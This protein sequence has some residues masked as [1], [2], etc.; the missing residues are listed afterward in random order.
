M[1][2]MTT[3]RL[4]CIEFVD[5][6]TDWEHGALTDDVRAE[7]EEHLALCPDCVDYVNQ[8]RATVGML[9]G[10]LDE[11][12]PARAREAALAVFRATRRQPENGDDAT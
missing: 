10:A 4:H 3:P 5:L 8:L 6:V 12:P 7:V 1:S 11:A 9:R 2:E